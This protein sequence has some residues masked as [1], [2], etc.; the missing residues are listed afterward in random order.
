MK[1]ASGMENSRPKSL[2]SK[3]EAERMA[4]PFINP[5]FFSPAVPPPPF[6]MV[7]YSFGFY[8]PIIT[9]DGEKG[10]AKDRT[11]SIPTTEIN[12]LCSP[13]LRAGEHKKLSETDTLE[14]FRSFFHEAGSFFKKVFEGPE[15]KKEE[16]KCWILN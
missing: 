7:W 2:T 5:F 8:F 3:V 9:K 13:A 10:K 4:A 12:H 11:G 1:L 14:K 15:S 16:P 6:A